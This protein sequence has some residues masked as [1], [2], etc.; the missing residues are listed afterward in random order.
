MSVSRCTDWLLSTPCSYYLDSQLHEKHRILSSQSPQFLEMQFFT[1]NTLPALHFVRSPLPTTQQIQCCF[2]LLLFV[3]FILGGVFA[4]GITNF[5]EILSPVGL[6]MLCLSR[7]SSHLPN[8][9]CFFSLSLLSSSLFYKLS[10]GNHIHLHK[11][12]YR[13][14]YLL[15]SKDSGKDIS[16]QFS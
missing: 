11:Y 7:L 5:P 14:L 12:K 13:Y 4:S 9:S 10:L 3:C 15:I 1:P 8:P 2:L 6:D 16:C